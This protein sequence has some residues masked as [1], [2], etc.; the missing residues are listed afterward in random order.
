MFG[1]RGIPRGIEGGPAFLGC[2][3]AG[4]RDEASFPAATALVETSNQH[5]EI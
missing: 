4:N 3:K 2:H 1:Q 5:G